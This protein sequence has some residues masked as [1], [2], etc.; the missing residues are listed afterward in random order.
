MNNNAFGIPELKKSKAK[1]SGGTQPNFKN[2]S[3]PAS[4]IAS[5]EAQASQSQTQQ[6]SLRE[7]GSANTSA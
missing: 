4:Q 1:I 5:D 7:S 2:V 6:N 3:I